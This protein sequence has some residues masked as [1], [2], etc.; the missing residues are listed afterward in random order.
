M[1]DP[2]KATLLG[3]PIGDE[4]SISDTLHD[5]TNLLP[6]LL[7]CLRTAPCFL[8]QGIQEYD[9]QLK[10]IVSGITNVHFSEASPT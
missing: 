1:V 9:E 6:K 8:S 2:T 4:L 7:Y 3:S 5:K 10:V